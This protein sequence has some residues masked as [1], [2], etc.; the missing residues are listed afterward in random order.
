[1]CAVINETLMDNH[2][3]E[4]LKALKAENY[5]FG[6]ETLTN[7]KSQVN[8]IAQNIFLVGINVP[9][10]RQKLKNLRDQ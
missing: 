7:L 9:E 8:A 5:I 2:Q 6:I 4:L 3:I 1:M 10:P